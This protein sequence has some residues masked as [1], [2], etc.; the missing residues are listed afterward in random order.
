VFFFVILLLP[1]AI[2]FPV[3]EWIA[4]TNATM[5]PGAYAGGYIITLFLGMFYISVGCLASALTKNQ[6]A[7]VVMALVAIFVIFLAGLLIPFSSSNLTPIL[8]D[9][10]TYFSALEHVANFSTGNYD[11]RPIVFYFTM[12]TFVLVVTY[13]VFQS[14]KWKS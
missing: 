9:L 12:T 8:R 14:R 1:T 6:I 7:A 10:T 2:Y 5:S 11:T 4:K 13:H 3:F